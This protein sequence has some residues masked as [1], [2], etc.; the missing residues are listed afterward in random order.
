MLICACL[1][2]CNCNSNEIN[3][4]HCS[5]ACDVYFIRLFDTAAGKTK[6]HV[7]TP[8]SHL[9]VPLSEHDFGRFSS[10]RLGWSMLKQTFIWHLSAYVRVKEVLP[11]THLYRLYVPVPAWLVICSCQAVCDPTRSS[12]EA[13]PVDAT[14]YLYL[15]LVL[16]PFGLHICE[17]WVWESGPI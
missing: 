10:W 3:A 7:K 17:A 15:H 6:K 5:A 8:I 2:A 14:R 4:C 16:Q 9:H 13:P 11:E 1:Y 12:H